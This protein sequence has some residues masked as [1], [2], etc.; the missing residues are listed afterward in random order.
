MNKNMISV[1]VPIYLSE[2]TLEELTQR[3]FNSI[4]SIDC[5]LEL[6]LVNDASPDNS[7][8]VIKK[9]NHNKTQIPQITST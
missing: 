5:E 3:V 1:V 6:I 8:E 2:N 7:W 9:L 4:K